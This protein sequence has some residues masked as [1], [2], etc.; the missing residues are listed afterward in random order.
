MGCEHE[1]QIEHSKWLER[2][3]ARTK[4]NTHRID[5][6]EEKVT[7]IQDIVTEIR[8]IALSTKHTQEMVEE[9]KDKVDILEKAEAEKLKE[10]INHAIKIIIGILIGAFMSGFLH[11][12]N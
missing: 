10:Y 9:L 11:S 7:T 4:S 1:V 6:V 8:T 2:L 3:E 12:F 5:S